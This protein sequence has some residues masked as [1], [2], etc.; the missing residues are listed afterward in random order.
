MNPADDGGNEEEV[1][2]ITN[3]A[4]PGVAFVDVHT[5]LTDEEFE[6]VRD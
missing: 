6:Q 4:A 5:H 1:T 3:M 2:L